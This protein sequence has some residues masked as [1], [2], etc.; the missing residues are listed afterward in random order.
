MSIVGGDM[1]LSI[2]TRAHPAEAAGRAALDSAAAD[3][4]AG[5]GHSE[6]IKRSDY[7][8][9]AMLAQSSV[10]LAVPRVSTQASQGQTHCTPSGGAK[11]D[12]SGGPAT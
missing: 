1:V 7:P 4:P 8:D 12:A 5:S 11:A 2:P 10:H 9:K 6:R 3:A